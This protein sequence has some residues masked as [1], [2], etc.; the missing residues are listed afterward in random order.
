MTEINQLINLREKQD[1][2]KYEFNFNDEKIFIKISKIFNYESASD[3]WSSINISSHGYYAYRVTIFDYKSK[4]S[5]TLLIDNS[6]DSKYCI[7]NAYVTK[8]IE[9]K[10][11]GFYEFKNISKNINEVFDILQNQVAFQINEKIDINNHII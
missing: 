5:V 6:Y 9:N 3:F 1:E 2:Y 10:N 4:I 11:T 7:I 8:Y